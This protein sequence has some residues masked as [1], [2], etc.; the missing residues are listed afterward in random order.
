[1]DFGIFQEQKNINKVFVVKNPA[2][3]SVQFATNATPVA[4]TSAQ[5]DEAIARI[6]HANVICD[7][8]DK[9]IYG[10]RYKCLEC[11]DFD[12]CMQCE[13]KMHNHHL[14]VR[15]TDPNDAEILY[16][17]RLG[18]RFMRH[19]RSES[20]CPK[21]DEKVL[22]KKLDDI[23]MK[24]HHKRHG[25]CARPNPIGDIVSSVLQ[26]LSQQNFAN[27]NNNTT[28]TNNGNN[29]NANPPQGSSNNNDNGGQ[30]PKPSPT[31]DVPK[32][33]KNSIDMFANIASN[34]ATMMDPFAT[35]VEVVTP[36]ATTAASATTSTN[37]TTQSSQAAEPMHVEEATTEKVS[38]LQQQQ[39]K[40]QEQPKAKDAAE[41]MI[42][43][44]SDNEDEDVHKLV[45]LLVSNGFKTTTDKTPEMAPTPNSTPKQV[46]RAVSIEKEGSP[47]REWTFINAAEVD[48]SLPSVQSTQSIAASTSTG[49]VPKKAATPEKVPAQPSSDVDY[50]E[51][52][53]LLNSHIVAQKMEKPV[54]I[55]QPQPQAASAPPQA[56]ISQAPPSPPR[57]TGKQ[58]VYCFP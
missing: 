36:T 47:I 26:S 13:T 43:D 18:K 39:Q 50:K 45:D 44:C 22:M 15:V 48:G 25:Q 35:F 21:L 2:A 28:N 55:A 46:E 51:L 24:H 56:P 9:E 42:V 52:S 11:P 3:K 54:E 10:Y 32:Y 41:V 8:C 34:F 40:Q 7:G 17:T 57:P 23:K 27:P 31:T 49:A 58:S 37:T 33:C 30:N 53:R 12:L 14:M 5:P 29:T 19:R 38:D 6:H 1:M 16:K 4:S 20:S